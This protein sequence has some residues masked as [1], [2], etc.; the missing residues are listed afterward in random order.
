MRSKY[1]ILIF[2]VLSSISFL[3]AQEEKDLM[4]YKI[5]EFSDKRKSTK[6]LHRLIFRREADS[7]SV[8]S[9][10]KELP[11]TSYNGKIIRN[12]EIETFDPFGYK[13]SD[14]SKDP[15]WYDRLA[16][17]V[18]ID[19]KK[20]TISN[21]LLFKKG[22][23]YNAQKIYESER[24]LRDMQFVNRVNI[25]INELPSSKDSIDVKVSVL[26]SWSLKPRLSFSG[27]K[28][29]VGA[30]EENLLGLG[31]ELSVLYANDFNDKQNNLYGS[32]TAYN[33]FGS[34]INVGISGEKDFLNNERINFSARRDFFSPLTRWAGGFTFEYFMR[35]VAMPVENADIYPEVQIKVYRQD[36]WGGYQ[37]PVFFGDG[38]EISRNIAVLGRFENYQY[39]DRPA[40]DQDVFFATYNSF[41]AS[42][43]YIERKFSVEKNIFKYNLP[44]D[45]PYGKSFGI[46]S[47]VI[48]RSSKITPYAGISAAV[49]SFINWGYFTVKAE[50]GRFFN[51]ATEN[52]DSFRLEGTYFTNQ[53]PWK[54]GKVRH[55]FSPTFAWGSEMYN[56]TYKDRINISDQSEFPAY[57][58]DFIGTKKLILRYQTQ[59]FIDKTWKN[60]HFSPYSIVALG[61]L[62]QNNQKLFSA[63]TQSKFG[64][65]VL[66]NNPYLVFNNIQI[67]FAYY[68]SVPFDNKP[69]YEFN[70]YRNSMLPLNSFSTDIPHFVNFDN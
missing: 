4:Y 24:V 70:G 68:P 64:I 43:A 60:F 20:S 48:K 12:I 34:F 61:W 63:K 65:G 15:K 50:Y 62:S 40:N 22:E 37:F 3:S 18:H 51:E 30:T 10:P 54:Y 9:N 69:A 31:H 16:E 53:Q 66:I 45:I 11:Q 28:F 17:R 32:Y 57:S 46:T 26:D 56:T 25:S 67:S 47:G 13:I 36:L 8:E 49:G 29:G 39:K 1:L 7:V 21:Y 41:L 23:E 44:E 42:A 2:F 19:S 5:E 35:K 55:F 6:F 27:S 38:S 14:Q 33:L 59:F 52:S 58:G